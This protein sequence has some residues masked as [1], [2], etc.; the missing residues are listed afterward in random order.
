MK[1]LTLLFL[2]AIT[3]SAQDTSG[4]GTLRVRVPNAPGAE[5]CLIPGACELLGPGNLVRFSSLRPGAYQVEIQ[6][7]R[8]AVEVRAGLEIEVEV[9]VAE[10]QSQRQTIEVTASALVAPEEV[11][12]SVH[13]VEGEDVRTSAAA[14]KDVSR[15][16][17]T[18]PGVVFGG[19]DFVNDLIVRGGHPQENL[20]IVDNVEVPNIN[21]FATLVTNGGVVGQFNSELLD[22]V[23][24]LT[25]GYPAAYNNRLSSVLQI[26]QREGSRE[27]VRGQAT[28]GW[29]GAG[30]VAE[31]P[32]GGKGS[33]IV[34]ARRS[35]WDAFTDDLGFG[36]V[37]IYTNLQ[38]KFVYDLN[39]S[40][41]LWFSSLGGRDNISV[42]PKADRKLTEA[43]P[44]NVDA[45]G[46]RNGAGL[47]WQQ[48]FGA[49]GV[50]LLGLSH[51]R[52][53]VDDLVK[54]IRL[55]N[56]TV[57]RAR[58]SDEE[59]AAKYDLT[60][61]V[62]GIR[63]L[64]AGA[65]M[66]WLR[67]N[68]RMEAPFGSENPFSPDV[69][70]VNPIDVSQ[71]ATAKQRSAYAQFSRALAGRLSITAGARADRYAYLNAT[72]ISPR[73]GLTFRIT[74]RL[75]AHAS[76]G[77]YYQQPAFVY[78]AIEP[79]N[80]GLI[81]MRSSHLVG[82][83]TWLPSTAM[84]VT[85]EAYEK[86]YADYPVALD[87]PRITLASTPYMWGAGYLMT[88]LTSAGR[89]RARGVEFAVEKKLTRHF[90]AQ[91][92]LTISSSRHAALDKVLRPGGYDSR[93]VSNLIGGYRFNDRWSLAARFVYVGGRPYTPF[94]LVKSTAQNRGVL[95]LARVNAVRAPEYNRLDL[96]VDRNLRIRGGLLNV[97]AGIQ[98][99]LGR[100]NFFAEVWNF[101]TNAPKTEHQLGAFPMFGM[102][103]RFR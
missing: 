11:R 19:N 42:R 52:T 28:A 10:L 24:F 101:R 48:L 34:S 30:G 18:L 37:P 62:P 55:A 92:N 56:S 15:H 64:Q 91:A 53:T 84:R 41:R 99:A 44:Y 3:L 22:G 7:Q 50:G 89:G 51:S 77:T 75:S 47:S 88:P 16:L 66:R 12:T 29:A 13:L 86:R 46:W 93:Y 39:A 23:T 63:R 98:N 6:K 38:S 1:Q 100:K 72:R 45:K 20:Y 61:D 95:D 102:E 79:V 40:N 14:L 59:F 31:G 33:W 85:I 68:Y 74:D 76:T 82:G 43:D 87:F 69:A 71:R 67:P 4:T 83:L 32:L 54:D 35:M 26:T 103:W 65:A 5:V 94:D 96:R 70:R 58:A 49:R 57:Y 80:R 25:G 2:A 81:P 60:L 90:H 21:H 17:Q 78:I 97:Y 36:G 27:R 9:A 8:T 73:V